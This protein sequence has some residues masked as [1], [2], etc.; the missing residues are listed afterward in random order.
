[1]MMDINTI[2]QV[3]SEY[4]SI[5]ALSYSEEMSSMD[6]RDEWKSELQ[7]R[8]ESCY[9]EK[10]PDEIKILELATGHGY[11]AA[12][13][14]ELGYSV[15]AVDMAP[16]MLAEAKKN[17]V[18][19]ANRIQ[20][21]EMN[22]EELSFEDGTFDVVFSR[23]LTW[24]L[25]RPEQAYSEWTRV[26]KP[27]GLMLTYDTMQMNQRTPDNENTSAKKEE[28]STRAK[29]LEKTGM[30]EELYDNLIDLSN[31][32]EIGYLKRPEWDITILT[33]LGV[34]ASSEDV[35]RLSAIESE[36]KKDDA[37][38]NK[39]SVMSPLILVKGIKK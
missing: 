22:A 18:Q 31:E 4:W 33:K 21:V 10:K 7:Q 1:M 15:T 26:L 38:G 28:N 32:L 23:F 9:P 5:R 27:G 20:F 34:D 29:L 2:K 24:L 36:S 3:F 11:F 37:D 30:R 14:A 35:I 39:T 25:P 6:K 19:F 8:I 17:Y 16:G 13:L 12:I